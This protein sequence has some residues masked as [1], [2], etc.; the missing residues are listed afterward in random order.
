MELKNS[1]GGVVQR[2]RA[3]CQQSL[4][5]EETVILDDCD[6]YTVNVTAHVPSYTELGSYTT[7]TP[8]NISF[9]CPPECKIGASCTD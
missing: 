5:I 3:E 2:T 1:A 4:L 9:I 6:S 7:I 8:F